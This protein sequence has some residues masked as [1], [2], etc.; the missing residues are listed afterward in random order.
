V[1][2]MGAAI[3]MGICIVCSIGLSGP[4]R[5]CSLGTFAVALSCMFGL[6]W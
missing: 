2:E 5:F 3:L 6:S 1:G 4:C